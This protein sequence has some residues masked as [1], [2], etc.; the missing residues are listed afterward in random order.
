MDEHWASY[1]Y[2]RFT[3]TTFRAEGVWWARARMA[4]KDVGGDRSVGGGPWRSQAD[5]KSAAE[6][7]CNAGSAGIPVPEA[8]PTPD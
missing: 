2:Q 1:R 7:F 8:K 4:E 5:A 6:L 3:I